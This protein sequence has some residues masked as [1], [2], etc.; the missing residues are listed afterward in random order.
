MNYSII[1]SVYK[2]IKLIDLKKSFNS[3][4]N[5]SIK[6]K[7]LIIVI[8]GYCDDKIIKFISTFLKKN[9]KNQHKILFNSKN[10]GIP[11]SYN[12]A[13]SHTKYNY[14][15]INDSDDFSIKNRFEK[16]LKFLIKNPSVGA[17]GSFIGERDSKKIKIKKVPIDSKKIKLISYFKN[18]VNHPTVMFNKS[19]FFKNI[20]YEE[21]QR[22]ED[23]FLW[24]RAINDKIVIKNM[25][26]TLVI[27]K[28]DENFFKRRT[29]YKIIKSEYK[30]QKF[31]LT[32]N[33][34]LIFLVL[35][36]FPLKSIYH[37]T[38]PNIKKVLRNFLNNLIW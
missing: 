21:C 20:K 19:C 36:I 11:Y 1:C 37:I 33:L 25:P 4:N 29:N 31:F 9:F 34:L 6:S 8:D 26:E 12:K 15:G 30:I 16:Q 32:K 38:S 27:S 5:Q 3:L 14:V 18:P 10:R 7:D 13:I 23:Y 28:I 35:I 22:M 24:I 2:N 17:V